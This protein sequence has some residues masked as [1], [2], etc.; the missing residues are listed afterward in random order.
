MELPKWHLEMNL[1][2]AFKSTFIIEGNIYDL[3]P[4]PYQTENG[5]DWYMVTLDSYLQNY[6][7][8]NGYKT[9]IFYNHIDGFYNTA[10]PAQTEQFNQMYKEE[11]NNTPKNNYPHCDLKSAV[12]M[13]RAVLGQ[14]HK[15]QNEKSTVAV[16]MNQASRYLASPSGLNDNEKEIFTKLLMT[17]LN[18]TQVQGESGFI[19]NLLFI[20]TSKIN[21]IP[22][23]LYI[24]NP[25]VKT[26]NIMKP[27]KEVRRNYID[28]QY[29][30]FIDFDKADEAERE[31]QKERFV[32]LTDG[33]KNLELQGLKTLSVQEQQ[34]LS[35]IDETIT[36]F[37]YGIKNNP[38]D[39]ISKE[40]LKTI[41]Q[42][43]RERVKGQNLSISQ[44]ID[45]IITAKSGMSGSQHSSSSSKPKGILFY[46]GPTGTG[47]TELAKALAQWLFGSERACIRFD[48]SEYQQSQS[49]QKL[50]G[51]PPGYVGYEAGGQLT[52][53]IKEK[54]FSI[55]LFDEIEK[56]HPSIMDK[57]LQILED[58]RMT[59]G[60]GETVFFSDTIIIF[61]SNLG[62]YTKDEY[63]RRV[64]NVTSDMEYSVL[65]ERV[66]QAIKDYFNLELGRPEILNRIGDNFAIFDYIRP[67]VAVQI[68]KSQLDKI[69]R[70]EM[71][72]SG[73]TITI[74]EKAYSNI[75]DLCMKNLNNGGR[76]IGNV[77]EK[78][79]LKPLQRY[80]F[81]NS[82]SSGARLTVADLLSVN[83]IVELEC[84]VSYAV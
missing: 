50:L 65:R 14:E 55:I 48:M 70:Q 6:L 80:I 79:F 64:P 4:Y 84:E 52:N 30:F 62:I 60:K 47:K 25:F 63:G 38:W 27:D 51:A 35:K 28:S 41:E 23:W 11:V 22:A 24:D 77:I 67:E 31:K 9:I 15:K 72:H 73:I 45:V 2:K 36:L 56:A 83:D 33:F 16:I 68:I 18:R 1:L 37:K 17:S 44:T 19:N 75:S 34:P 5:T 74:G 12:D 78:Y 29:R 58:G 43:L 8:E 61:T 54:P 3:Q 57:F 20:V 53:A 59:D 39:E 81:N 42:S 10:E 49:D 7:K 82:I 26:L 66:M 13:I 76:G 71:E 46:A 40:R 32:A 21:D 69:C